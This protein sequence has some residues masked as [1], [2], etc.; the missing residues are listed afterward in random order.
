[1]VAAP[2][3]LLIAGKKLKEECAARAIPAQ[4]TCH[5]VPAQSIWLARRKRLQLISSFLYYFSLSY[6]DWSSTGAEVGRFERFVFLILDLVCKAFVSVLG[7]RIFWSFKTSRFLL[8]NL[9][10]MFP[11]STDIVTLSLNVS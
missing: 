3:M 5:M 2:G 9:K 7:D 1:M 6:L 8:E 10:V 11:F 4:F